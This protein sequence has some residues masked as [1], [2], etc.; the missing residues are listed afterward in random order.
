L[1]FN[2]I[3]ICFAWPSGAG[4]ER[5]VSDNVMAFSEKSLSHG[6]AGALA[7]ILILDQ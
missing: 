1:S 2:L 5:V 4:T 6:Y 3:S 7:S